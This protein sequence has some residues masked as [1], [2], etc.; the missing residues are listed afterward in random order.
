MFC[1]VA[2]QSG[3]VHPPR[4]RY[5]KSGMLFDQGFLEEVHYQRVGGHPHA[6]IKV[7]GRPRSPLL[8]MFFTFLDALECFPRFGTSSL[9][10]AAAKG[11]ISEFTRT[12]GVLRVSV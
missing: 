6:L 2:C 7:L 4:L 5:P 8:F 12:E 11:R 10:Q 3:P 1:H 9:L